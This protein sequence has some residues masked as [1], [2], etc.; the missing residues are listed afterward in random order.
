MS[1]YSIMQ[2]S[3]FWPFGAA[4]DVVY[5]LAQILQQMSTLMICLKVYR[6]DACTAQDLADDMMQQA[7]KLVAAEWLPAPLRCDLTFQLIRMLAEQ[8]RGLLNDRTASPNAVD[9]SH[10]YHHADAYETPCSHALA[11]KCLRCTSVE[12]LH[13]SCCTLLPLVWQS[14]LTV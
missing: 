13:A 11:M 4:G 14:L 10:T 5:V 8:A 2:T 9:R 1:D 7:R 6:H 3:M 12:S